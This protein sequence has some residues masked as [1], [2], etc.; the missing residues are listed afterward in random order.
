MAR[1]A[2]MVTDHCQSVSYWQ[3]SQYEYYH[4]IKYHDVVQ[5]SAVKLPPATARWRRASGHELK[6]RLDLAMNYQIAD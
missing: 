2:A 1:L 4:N 6:V 5:P 3:V